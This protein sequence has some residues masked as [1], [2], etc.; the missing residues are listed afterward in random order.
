MNENDLVFFAD[1]MCFGRFPYLSTS[2][3]S[4]ITGG[5]FQEALLFDPMSKLSLVS[6]KIKSAGKLTFNKGYIDETGDYVLLMRSPQ[7]E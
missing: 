6:Q 4:I 1:T 5:N 2:A 3:V 7:K